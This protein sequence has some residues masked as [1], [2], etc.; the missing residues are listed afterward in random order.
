MAHLLLQSFVVAAAVGV[1]GSKEVVE[2]AGTVDGGGFLTVTMLALDFLLV[3][4]ALVSG[5]AFAA[6]VAAWPKVLLVLT[7]GLWFF[8]GVRTGG[9]KVAGVCFF[10]VTIFV[11]MAAKGFFLLDKAATAA[12]AAPMLDCG[13]L[14]VVEERCG[15][16]GSLLV[17]EEVD[18][19]LVDVFFSLGGAWVRLELEDE[20]LNLGLLC[21]RISSWSRLSSSLLSLLP[22]PLPVLLSDSK[23][24]RIVPLSFLSAIDTALLL[25][26]EARSFSSSN[27]NKSSSLCCCVGKTAT[28][29]AFFFTRRSLP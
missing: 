29:F 12:T 5:A 19:F 27:A 10:L 8:L 21:S 7:P 6:A 9:D 13:F 16:C 26:E 20:C 23:N 2:E 14:L 4:G 24:L 3:D 17:V 25:E 28:R 22:L 15:G 18:S 11:L 1:V